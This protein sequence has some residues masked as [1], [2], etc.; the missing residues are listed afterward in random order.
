MTKGMEEKPAS[1]KCTTPNI[2]S[3]KR[4][5]E[6][7]QTAYLRISK[8]N[9][10]RRRRFPTISQNDQQITSS[11]SAVEL[12]KPHEFG[13]VVTS[14]SPFP[15]PPSISED[16]LNLNLHTI[17]VSR[18]SSIPEFVGCSNWAKSLLYAQYQVSRSDRRFHCFGTFIMIL[19][20]LAGWV[21]GRM[22]DLYLSEPNR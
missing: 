22:A 2:R 15:Y 3:G 9:S 14:R 13:G 12:K 21:F 7:G 17:K 8:T 4:E 18:N 16:Y 6:Q 11:S 1:S 5:R 20:V 10:K 19:H